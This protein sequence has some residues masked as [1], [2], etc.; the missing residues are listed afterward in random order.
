MN[1]YIKEGGYRSYLF[2]SYNFYWTELSIIKILTD[3]LVENKSVDN[4]RNFFCKECS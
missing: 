4:C 1:I 2:Y 3:K